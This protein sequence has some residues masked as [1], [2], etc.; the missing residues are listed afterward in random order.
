MKEI[1][2]AQ[3][4]TPV[5]TKGATILDAALKAGVPFPHSCRAGEC[6]ACQCRLI[7][8]EVAHDDHDPQALSDHDR[9]AGLILACRATPKTNVEVAWPAS[10]AAIA[11]P[12]RRF[13]AKVREIERAAK[14]VTIIRLAAEGEPLSFAAGQFARLCFD[15]VPPRSYSMANMPGDGLLEFH[16]RHVDG[17]LASAHVASRLRVGDTVEL[18]GPHGNAYLRRGGSGSIVAIG[19]GTGLAPLLSIIKTALSEKPD[20]EIHLYF[21]VRTEEDIYAESELARI[22]ALHESFSFEIVLS[23]ASAEAVRRRSYLHEALSEDFHSLAKTEI[24]VAGSN[25]MVNAVTKAA[26]ERGADYADIYAD[27]FLPSSGNTEENN[28][29]ARSERKPGWLSFFGKKV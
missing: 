26:L 27:R 10:G 16:I 13:K 24:Y 8:G 11:Y 21:G 22:G 2:I 17:G 20:R 28:G 12:V 15:G 4:P 14:N 18:E 6:G 5:T 29:K 3:W 19:G 23:N 7:S 25:E 9:A 1:R